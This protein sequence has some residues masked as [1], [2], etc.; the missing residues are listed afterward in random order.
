QKYRTRADIATIMSRL[1]QERNDRQ[2]LAF[3]DYVM[4]VVDTLKHDGMSD[5]EDGEVPMTVG[6]LS[7][8]HGVKKIM[9]LHWRH[10]WFSDL[11]R[12]VDSAP[13][14]EKLIFHRAGRAHILRIPVDEA[15]FRPP[16]VGLS[17][18]YFRPNYLENLYP[19]DRADLQISNIEIPV[20]N[21]V[22]FDPNQ[23]FSGP[24]QPSGTQP[25]PSSATGSG[26]S[27][28]AFSMEF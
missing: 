3:W 26:N 21:F 5:E 1:C 14:I 23:L 20:Y 7:R 10:P 12:I 18:S 17:V 16:P 28:S 19:V 25:T 24:V 8:N 27:G 11:F 4:H 2:G 13:A 6:G 22:G 15:T 9:V